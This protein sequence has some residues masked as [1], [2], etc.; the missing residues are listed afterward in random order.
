MFGLCLL[1]KP[2]RFLMVFMQAHHKLWH[3]M[4]SAQSYKLSCRS[5]GRVS[6][7]L[8]HLHSF[9]D[10][11]KKTLKIMKFYWHTIFNSILE[12]YASSEQN[13]KHWHLKVKLTGSLLFS[14]LINYFEI[15]ANHCHTWLC[16]KNIEVFANQESRISIFL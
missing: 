15:L 11:Q 10:S 5:L 13:T 4:T 16:S 1:Y 7:V 2:V 3:L 6:P 8:S 14:K 12:I 9:P